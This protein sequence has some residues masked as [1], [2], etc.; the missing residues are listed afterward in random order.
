LKAHGDGWRLFP[1]SKLKHG[2]VSLSGI[3]K[4]SIRGQAKIMGVPKTAEILHKNGSWYLS[5]TMNCEEIVRESGAKAIGIDWGTQTFATIVDHQNELETI[6]NPRWGR[7]VSEKIKIQH[8]ALSK[9][10][11]GSQNRKK[12]IKCLAQ[13]Y[14]KLHQQR[15]NFLHQK[16]T[17]IIKKSQLIATE[18]LDISA[19][20][21]RGHSP[22][23]KGLNR[24]ILDT[25]PRTFFN[26]LKYK[27]EEAGIHWIDVPTRRVKP[28]QTCHQ[29][30]VQ[31]KKTLSHRQ[32]VCGCGVQC[33]RD[34][35][36]AK[37]MLNWALY[38]VSSGQELSEL[39]RSGSL[40]PEKQETL[41]IISSAG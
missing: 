29:C 36:A 39:W 41:S 32:H 12:R 21:R 15:K 28:S 40:A 5:V 23:K 35:N 26:L 13:T 31:K 34:E 37:V 19:M 17:E 11:K 33:G 14:R 4:I 20:T 27:A 18:K 10:K 2:Q 16:S 1:G 30:G 6:T 22:F 7:T 3:G 25:A 24:E 8:R 9:S 38:G